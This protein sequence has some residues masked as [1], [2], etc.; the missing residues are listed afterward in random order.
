MKPLILLVLLFAVS[1]EAKQ[2]RVIYRPASSETG[3]LFFAYSTTSTDSAQGNNPSIYLNPGQEFT[4][5]IPEKM[6][7]WY[8]IAGGWNYA[9]ASTDATYSKHGLEIT[10]YNAAGSSRLVYYTEPLKEE[11]VSHLVAIGIVLITGLALIITRLYA[12]K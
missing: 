2:V 4:Y 8:Y 5:S 12:H 3:Q 11:Y 6:R 7:I 9:A 1:L 10:V